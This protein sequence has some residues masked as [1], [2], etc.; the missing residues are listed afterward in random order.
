MSARSVS[1][2][3]L[4]ANCTTTRRRPT[5]SGPRPARRTILPAWRPCWKRP[6]ITAAGWP[7]IFPGYEH[8]IDPLID[9]ADYGMKAS[10]VQR[11]VRRPAH[12]S[13]SRS[14]RPSPSQPPADDACLR[15]HF[16]AGRRRWL[17]AREVAEQ[18]GYDFQRG[19]MDLTHHPFE[20][21][22]SRRRCAHHHP[23][24]R[25]LSGRM[26]VQRDP[27]RRAC[28]VRAGRAPRPGG[29]PAGRRHI[30]RRARKPVPPVGEHRRAQPRLLPNTSTRGC[31][32]PSRSN[33]AACPL[34]TFYR[35]INRVE[36]SLIRT[37]ADEV[38]YNLHVMLRFDFEMA[39][40]EGTA[41]GARSAGS[42]A[43]AL[44]SRS[45]ASP[46][47]TTATA[48]C[49]M[50]TG[51]AGSSAARS[52]AT[53]WATSSAPLFYSAALQAHPA[54]PAAD[55]PGRVRHTARLADR[56]HLP[57]RQQIHRRRADRA[58]HR[59]PDPHRALH[60]AISRPSTAS[61]TLFSAAPAHP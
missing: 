52:R 6:W 35:A 54:N 28:H 26:P 24:Q 34:E 13:W 51:M 31:R 23:R 11:A 33:S 36:R 17:S 14:S 57:A 59:R 55:P 10:T 46:R 50:S 9:Y 43:R 21:S 45:S 27:R 58:R 8:I 7:N 60:P 49:R 47:Q 32:R 19:R 38:T 37:D 48:C 41:G 25:K 3:I 61:C 56:K 29:H 12:A 16:P 44:R 2:R 15:K 1:R 5:R 4:S 22:F 42:L 20:T 40:L 18:M 53:P 39:L 30:G